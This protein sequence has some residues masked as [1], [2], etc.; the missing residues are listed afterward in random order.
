MEFLALTR[1]DSQTLSS[2]FFYSLAIEPHHSRDEAV[3]T[4]K[5]S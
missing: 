1:P 5:N 4:E 2:N 3:E